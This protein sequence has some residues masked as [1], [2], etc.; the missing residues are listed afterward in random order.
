MTV[1]PTIAATEVGRALGR[2]YEIRSGI[3]IFT[4]G[5]LAM[6]LTSPIA[7]AVFFWM[8]RPW[9][10]RRYR[11]TNRRITIET[12]PS[13]RVR[14]EIGLGEF[15]TILPVIL[16]GQK[17]YRSGELIFLQGTTERFSLKGVSCPE[18]FRQTCLKARQAYL[19]AAQAGRP[20]YSGKS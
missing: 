19:G 4:V 7:L 5:R 20:A 2:L 8:L 9:E 18:Q 1:W 15:D 12:G 3:W 11:L 10:G 17:W 13:G 16:P 14:K 6:F